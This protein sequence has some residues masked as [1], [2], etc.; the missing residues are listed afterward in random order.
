MERLVELIV[1]LIVGWELPRCRAAGGT[2]PK[3]ARAAFLFSRT[4]A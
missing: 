4:M 2:G 3:H 1:E